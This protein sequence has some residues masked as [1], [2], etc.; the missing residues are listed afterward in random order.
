MDA[1][2]NPQ[3]VQ[4]S[5]AELRR[6]RSRRLMARVVLCVGL[7]TLLGIVYYGFIASDRYESVAPV[8]VQSADTSV[9]TGFE[10]LIGIVP[11]ASSSRDALSVREYVLSRDML[12][13]LD[14]D[15]GYIAHAQ[16]SEIDFWSRLS[17]DATFED[18]YDYYLDHVE[19]EFDSMS[20]VL[21]L[22]VQ[23]YSPEKAHAFAS[24]I[25]AN[26]EAMVNHLSDRVRDDATAFAEKQVAKAEHRLKA[27]RQAVTELQGQGAELDP[28]QS[29]TAAIHLRSELQGELARTRAELSETRAFMRADAPKVVA[30]SQRVASLSRQVAIERKRLVDPDKDEGMHTELAKFEVAILE[31]EFAQAAYKSAMTSLEMARIEAGRKHRYLVAIAPPSTPDQATHPRRIHGMI[32]VF[33]L[34]LALFG[35]ASLLVASIR[36]H[37]RV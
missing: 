14:H 13:K 17:A 6:R 29:A 16:S 34:S 9:G 3:G 20:G 26:S 31:K 36:E 2:A 5:L 35:I 30:L 15:H 24:A 25:L 12:S 33:A 18:A 10:S 21:T 19:A 22:R 37:A 11:G 32:S 7:P 1:P 4:L 28:A 8:I 23:A 27:A